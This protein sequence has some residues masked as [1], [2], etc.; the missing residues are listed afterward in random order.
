MNALPLEKLE[1][2][3]VNSSEVQAVEKL[4]EVMEGWQRSSGFG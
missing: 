3:V 1:A 2:L 4:P